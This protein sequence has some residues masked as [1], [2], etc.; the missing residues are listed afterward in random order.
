VSEAFSPEHVLKNLLDFVDSNR[1]RLFDFESFFFDL[2]SPSA[3]VDMI[4]SCLIANRF[5]RFV[6][7][8]GPGKNLRF[9]LVAY[10]RPGIQE[11]A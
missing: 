3:S 10:A 4:A 7:W 6:F 2:M 5:F 9:G 8:P 1:R 11:Q